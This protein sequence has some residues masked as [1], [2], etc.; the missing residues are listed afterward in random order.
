MNNLLTVCILPLHA[1]NLP[2][3]DVFKTT[4]IGLSY[5]LHIYLPSSLMSITRVSQPLRTVHQEEASLCV[6]KTV[7][8]AAKK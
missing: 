2:S 1:I 6:A 4:I 8:D 3:V 7:L 5:N